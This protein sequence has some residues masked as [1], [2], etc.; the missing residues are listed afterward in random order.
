MK[1]EKKSIKDSYKFNLVTKVIFWLLVA[2]FLV[3]LVVFFAFRGYMAAGFPILAISG[4][5]VALL[6]IT[7]IIITAK[8]GIK[9]LLKKFLIITGAAPIGIVVR[10]VLHNV[11]YGV[12]IHFFGADFWE[13]TGIGDQPVFFFLAIFICP[14]ALLV[15][16]VGSIVLFIKGRKTI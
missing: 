4:I 11:L 16:I 9:G 5:I 3:L 13:R 6:G 7:L 10:A 8:S 12:F 1:P 15:G 2:F 14:I